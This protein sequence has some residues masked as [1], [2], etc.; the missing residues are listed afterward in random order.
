MRGRCVLLTGPSG[1]G[2]SSACEMLRSQ[3]SRVRVLSQDAFFGE[4]LDYSVALAADDERAEL[5][6]HVNWQRIVADV[7]SA[8]LAEELIIVEGHCVV[9]CEALV[10]SAACVINLVA[11]LETC[12]DRRLARRERTEAEAS[13]LRSYYDRIAARAHC[14]H[15]APALGLL[16]ER[17]D[18]PVFDILSEGSLDLVVAQVVT[19]ILRLGLDT[20]RTSGLERRDISGSSHND[21]G[22][23][24][25]HSSPGAV[26]SASA[27]A[28]VPLLQ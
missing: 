19:I 14:R 4:P 21:I 8:R 17:A 25:G 24:L 1:V 13:I 27:A 6:T 9:Q 22:I 3:L 28:S 20:P 11:P 2:K 15:V 18:P 16:R 26:S 5:H 10:R 7:E 12:R 23:A